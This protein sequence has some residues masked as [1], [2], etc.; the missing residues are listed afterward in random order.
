MK[1][2]QANLDTCPLSA[3]QRGG[4]DFC[5][6]YHV[7]AFKVP[8]NRVVSMGRR[9]TNLNSPASTIIVSLMP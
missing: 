9:N 8:I 6:E 3:Y 2:A 5:A 1:A 7:M 4:S